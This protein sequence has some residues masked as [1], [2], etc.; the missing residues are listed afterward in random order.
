MYNSPNCWQDGEELME[1]NA[2]TGEREKFFPSR[3]R[4]RR[5]CVS[6]IVAVSC[7]NHWFNLINPNTL[8]NTATPAIA[9]T[10]EVI[11]LNNSI[12]WLCLSSQCSKF[13]LGCPSFWVILFL[14]QLGLCSYY[15]NVSLF[16]HGFEYMISHFSSIIF[17]WAI[18]F[19]IISPKSLEYEQILLI[20]S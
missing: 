19:R 13:P 14:H 3:K 7:I 5:T 1:R 2:I 8:R 9:A 11:V 12:L 15:L 4:Q 16:S 18:M 10:A 6:T 17:E 20:D